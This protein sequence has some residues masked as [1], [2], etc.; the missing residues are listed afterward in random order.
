MGADAF[1]I[2][3]LLS[4]MSPAEFV[5]SYWAKKPL[6]VPGTPDKFERWFHMDFFRECVA[7]TSNHVVDDPVFEKQPEHMIATV[8]FANLR[9]VNAFSAQ[10][11][12]LSQ[13]NLNFIIPT[14]RFVVEYASTLKR[15][16]MYPG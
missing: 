13:L 9:S 5:E 10:F 1:G 8:P 12:V 16:L 6:Y 4:P 11:D 7:G 15:E 3:Y 2:E 14:D